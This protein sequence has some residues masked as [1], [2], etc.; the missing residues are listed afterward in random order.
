M[1]SFIVLNLAFSL[2]TFQQYL[3]ITRSVDGFVSCCDTLFSWKYSARERD[4]QHTHTLPQTISSSSA[5][6]TWD[7][8]CKVFFFFFFMVI[9]IVTLFECEEKSAHRFSFLLLLL[10]LL[11]SLLFTFLVFEPKII[12]TNKERKRKSRSTDLDSLQGLSSEWT[13]CVLSSGQTH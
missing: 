5:N 9:I 6:E 10:L 8:F 13:C 2:L 11:N 7:L 12:E 1:F 4:E 3:L